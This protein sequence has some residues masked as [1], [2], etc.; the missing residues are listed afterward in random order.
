MSITAW[1]HQSGVLC[2]NKMVIVANFGIITKFSAYSNSIFNIY[3]ELINSIKYL[4]RY[5]LIVH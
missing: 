2:V 4:N 1:E 5:I 3:R